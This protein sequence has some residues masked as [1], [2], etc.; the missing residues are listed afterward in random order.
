MNRLMAAIIAFYITLGVVQIPYVQQLM[1]GYIKELT[2]PDEAYA[3]DDYYYLSIVNPES[4]FNPAEEDQEVYSKKLKYMDYNKVAELLEQLPQAHMDRRDG[5]TFKLDGV[6]IAVTL[7]TDTAE[8]QVSEIEFQLPAAH[9]DKGEHL[10]QTLSQ[11]ASQL[12]GTKL[13]DYS[14]K[15]VYQ[16]QDQAALIK[17]I[18]DYNN[19]D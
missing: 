17:A 10:V 18:S 1:P 12:E 15:K 6:E 19:D 8:N 2:A 5:Y 14:G 4:G 3:E 9:L 7:Y 13:F 16:L 11:V